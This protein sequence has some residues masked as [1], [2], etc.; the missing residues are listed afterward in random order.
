MK[1]HG[2]AGYWLT[3]SDKKLFRYL[4]QTKVATAIQINRDIYRYDKINTLYHR[5]ALLQK[6]GFIRSISHQSLPKVKI[7]NLSDKG[8]RDFVSDGTER[9][10]EL[11]SQAILHDLALVDI[12]YC[13]LK[14]DKVTRFLTENE[15]R[16]WND[17]W[18]SEMLS[19]FIDVRCDGVAFTQLT[20]GSVTLAVEYESSCKSNGRVDEIVAKYYRNGDIPG[21]LFVCEDD[22]V[23]GLFVSSETKF[24]KEKGASGNNKFFYTKLE[25]LLSDPAMA[26]TDVEG[27]KLK[28]GP[29]QSKAS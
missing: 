22:E 10:V 25:N 24:L 6:L 4:H 3:Q 13:L 28:L 14:S 21:V 18:Q 17:H 23:Q 11:K 29:A 27:N 8:F 5:L 12:R 26:F 7:L 1:Q 19:S 2:K 15:L 20:G 16:T 9:L